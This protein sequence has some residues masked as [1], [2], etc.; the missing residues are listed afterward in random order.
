M[1][2]TCRI[3][4]CKTPHRKDTPCMACMRIMSSG[5]TMAAYR[6]LAAGHDMKAVAVKVDIEDML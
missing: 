6:A 5:K 1:K 3:C 4:G 2:G